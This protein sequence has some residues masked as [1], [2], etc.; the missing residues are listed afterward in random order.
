MSRRH[1]VSMAAV[2]GRS[3]IHRHP[4]GSCRTPRC[5]RANLFSLSQTGRSSHAPDRSRG[6][7][8]RRCG[9][10]PAP[11]HRPR[12][13]ATDGSTGRWCRRAIRRRAR[14]APRCGRRRY[15]VAEYSRVP[16]SRRSSHAVTIVGPRA[17]IA[18]SPSRAAAGT[19][20]ITTGPV[21][22]RP[23]SSER[24][25]SR[26]P[27]CRLPA[28]PAIAVTTSASPDTAIRG[29]AMHAERKRRHRR[30]RRQRRK[31]P[32]AIRRVRDIDRVGRRAGEIHGLSVG[33][34]LRLSARKRR[35][36]T[37]PLSEHSGQQRSTKHRGS[38]SS[39]L[40]TAALQHCSTAAPAAPQLEILLNPRQHFL[41][42][43]RAVLR[44]EDPVALVGKDDEPRG[45][46]LPLQRGEELE[47]LRVGDAEVELSAR[48]PASASCTRP[49]SAARRC[50]DQR[51]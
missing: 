37:R 17:A 19:S 36:S 35:A 4:S 38:N 34:Q 31:R 45:N 30:D 12:W 33:R 47:A 50:G 40:S 39:H 41:V 15:D 13:P 2:G 10:S 25:A 43:E 3:Q 23:P 28:V 44:L 9:T 14:P 49:N 11:C 22:V 24:Q 51:S 26:S 5:P 42:P 27:S 6:G 29:T 21:Q 32:S 7:R 8:P 16:L 46:A 18:C 20:L 48:S 1:T